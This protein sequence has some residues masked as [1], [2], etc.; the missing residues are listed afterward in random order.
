MSRD[1]NNGWEVSTP[2]RICLLGEHQDY[3]GLPVIAAAIDL[4]LSLRALRPDPDRFILDMP[5]LGTY[6]VLENTGQRQAYQQERDYLRSAYNLMV[7]MGLSWEHGWHCQARGKIPINAGTSSST[8]LVLSW[9]AFLL[10]AAGH[11][12]CADPGFVAELAHR[13]EVLEFGEPGGMMDHYSCSF[14][15]LIHVDPAHPVPRRLTPDLGAFVLGDSGQPKDTRGVLGSVKQL[16]LDA[17][18]QITRVLPEFDL[19]TTSLH[20]VAPYLKTLPVRQQEVLTANLVDRDLLAQGFALLQQETLD[21]A[22]LGHLLTQHHHQLSQK[23]QISTPKIDR[24]LEAAIA[25][26]ALGGKINGSGGG[27]CMFAYAPN[28][29]QAVAA[30]IREAGGRAFVI[31][32]CPGLLIK[33]CKRFSSLVWCGHVPTK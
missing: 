20:Q 26:G 16:A 27:G 21:H 9:V 25:A 23:K 15:N 29:S 30:A 14:G 1:Q 13:A 7:D 10:A 31:H 12:K 11:P 4:R 19:K 8:A 33:Q 32:V 24:M 28:H 18:A 3:L 5:D 17:V 2:G 22:Q 6:Y